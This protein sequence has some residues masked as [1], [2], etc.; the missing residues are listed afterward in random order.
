MPAFNFKL[1][2]I[3]SRMYGAPTK[4]ELDRIG[5][6]ITKD[7]LKVSFQILSLEATKLADFVRAE[8]NA[9]PSRWPP[10]NEKYVEWKDR[11]GLSPEMMKATQDYINAIGVQE[12]RKSDGKFTNFTK[13]GEG[14]AFTIR[15]GL[16]YREHKGLDEEG[17]KENIK[18]MDLANIHEFG[19]DKIPARP[20]WGPAHRRW[21]VTSKYVSRAIM[22]KVAKDL[23]K[24][25][26]AATVPKNRAKKI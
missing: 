8:I 9:Q 15:V 19:T 2:T 1:F 11:M 3:D 24:H 26:K 25:I 4:K 13:L 20:H 5:K 14:E 17:D 16:P 6:A 21:L 23:A 7:P 12:M 18:L 22:R 10:L